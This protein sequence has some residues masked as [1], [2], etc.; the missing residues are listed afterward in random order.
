MSLTKNIEFL[1]LKMGFFNTRSKRGLTITKSQI[2]LK[3]MSKSSK[4]LMKRKRGQQICN[5][6]LYI[7]P[8]K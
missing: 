1:P 8:Q 7:S 6:F 4:E 5:I 3:C 2:S